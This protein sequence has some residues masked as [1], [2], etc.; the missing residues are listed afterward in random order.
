MAVVAQETAPGCGKLDKS[1]SANVNPEFAIV[2]MVDNDLG[3]QLRAIVASGA[4]G[5]SMTHPEN[6]PLRISNLSR[7]TIQRE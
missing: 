5:E 6:A 2:L 3:F 4:G 1:I 7:H